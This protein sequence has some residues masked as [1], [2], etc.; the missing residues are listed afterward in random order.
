MRQIKMFFE[1]KSLNSCI[2]WNQYEYIG[3]FMYIN[4]WKGLILE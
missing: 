3:Y 4:N 1:V 2:K